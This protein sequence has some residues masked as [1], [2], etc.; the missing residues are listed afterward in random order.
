MKQVTQAMKFAVLGLATV[1][2]TST[3]LA[4]AKTAGTQPAPGSATPATKAAVTTVLP[5]VRDFAMDVS[6]GILTV[7]GM[8]GKAHMNY[9]VHDGFLYFTI[10]GVGTAIVAQTRFM[11]AAPQKNAFHG[12]T[13]TFNANGH[14]VEL[15]NAN[16]LV[17]AKDA[18]AWVSV[19]P[20]YG[21]N[22]RYP[23]MGFGS[24]KERPYAW[25]GSEV[26]KQVDPAAPPLP[27]ALQPKPATA[28]TYSVVVPASMLD[29]PAGKGGKSG[30]KN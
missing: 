12:S 16:P 17:G 30:K 18:E 2:L 7:D 28:S 5:S 11:N 4:Q 1:G 29:A 21:A 22:K 3:V 20:L 8:V 9:H 14:T 24:Q 27:K 26:A 23:M 13:L 6:D 10:P 15:S 25:P 19:D